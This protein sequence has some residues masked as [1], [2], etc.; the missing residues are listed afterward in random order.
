[1]EVTLEELESIC[2]TAK[3]HA[4]FFLDAKG[5]DHADDFTLKIRAFPGNNMERSIAIYRNNSILLKKPI[6]WINIRIA[7]I[8]KK[9]RYT[10]PLIRM[11]TAS[12]IHEW[13]HAISNFLRVMKY[14]E[15]KPI[16][17]PIVDTYGPKEEIEAE[18]FVEWIMF[19]KGDKRIE[20]YFNLAT[21]EFN[22][23]R[24]GFD[25]ARKNYNKT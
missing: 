23:L 25:Y 10:D 4:A 8:L 14:I 24:K 15:K 22:Y 1:M 13:W 18:E 12:I 2:L 9:L 7:E 5:F 17:T 6:F 19:D 21:K 20:L 11:V 16:K 3:K